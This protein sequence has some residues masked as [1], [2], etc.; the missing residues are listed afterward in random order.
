ML[1]NCT[2]VAAVTF[3]YLRVQGEKG[4]LKIKVFKLISQS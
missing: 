1:C 3:I 4:P 2:S